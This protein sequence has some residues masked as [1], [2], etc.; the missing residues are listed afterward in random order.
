MSLKKL[1]LVW[2]NKMSFQKSFNFKQLTIYHCSYKITVYF[3][4]S[5]IFV[6]LVKLNNLKNAIF[7]M[8][9][10]LLNVL[11]EGEKSSVL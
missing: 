8:C 6:M 2:C 7:L 5:W 10:L 11:Y 4:S 9:L 1:A 3:T